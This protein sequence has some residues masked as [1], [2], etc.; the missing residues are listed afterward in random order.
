MRRLFVV[1]ALF[2]LLL[3]T[4][5]VGTAHATMVS[6]WINGKVLCEWY[7]VDGG[8]GDWL[9]TELLMENETTKS[10]VGVLESRWGSG[11]EWYSGNVTIASYGIAK[12]YPNYYAHKGQAWAEFLWTQSGK[13]KSWNSLPM[14]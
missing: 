12:R 9:T 4:M 5:G 8:N 13:T 1:P 3:L 2:V 11:Y 10:G 7:Y 14:R 6:G